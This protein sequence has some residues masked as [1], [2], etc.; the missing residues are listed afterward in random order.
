M[1]FDVRAVPVEEYAAWLASTHASATQLDAARY[2]Q[3]AAPSR[4]DEAAT[5]GQVTAG[6]FDSIVHN[7]G[8]PIGLVP[9]S[10]NAAERSL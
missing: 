6:L 7:H 4:G 3:L 2:A 10:A 8:A 1:R 9:T 5:F